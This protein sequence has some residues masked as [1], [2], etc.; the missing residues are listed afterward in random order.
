MTTTTIAIQPTTFKKLPDG[1]WG[2]QGPD[3]VPGDV[4]TV[5]KA[6]GETKDVVVGEVMPY[7]TGFGNN[8][9]TIAA[10]PRVM[11]TAEVTAEIAAEVVVPDGRY[12]VYNDDQSVNDIAFYKVENVTEGRWAGWTFVKQIVGG[13][14]QK[15][16]QRQGKAITAKIAAFGLCQASELYGKST[17]RCGVCNTNLTNKDS[18]ERGIGPV[19]AANNG[20]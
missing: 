7:V 17:Q 12:A 13:D 3:L 16:S 2:I 1:T 19:C 11:V 20:W 14:E 5:S 10:T 15:L 6:N 8:V 18:R 9:A 4:V